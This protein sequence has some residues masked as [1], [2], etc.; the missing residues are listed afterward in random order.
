MEWGQNAQ[1]FIDYTLVLQEYGGDNN[2]GR[3]E[4]ENRIYSEIK[5]VE[6]LF[7]ERLKC[8]SPAK[9]SEILQHSLSQSEICV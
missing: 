4:Y 5:T 9:V 8:Q 2:N 1:E 7:Y 6:Q 3:L